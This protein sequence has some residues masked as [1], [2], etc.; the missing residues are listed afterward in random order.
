MRF[1]TYDNDN[2]L[3]SIN[4]ADVFNGGWWFNNCM[5]SQLNGPYQTSSS[6]QSDG[7]GVMWYTWKLYKYSLKRAEMKIRPN[8]G[9]CTYMSLKTNL[10]KMN[11]ERKVIL[12]S[13]VL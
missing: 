13:T 9:T 12:S 2:D 3:S 5:H 6:V 10:S 11:C 4:C 8:P 1:S 7:H